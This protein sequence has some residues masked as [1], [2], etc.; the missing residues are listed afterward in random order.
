MS[1]YDLHCAPERS[2]VDGT[3]PSRPGACAPDRDG[4]DAVEPLTPD[5]D[6][7]EHDELE[8][9]DPVIDEAALPALDTEDPEAPLREPGFDDLIDR[10]WLEKAA[11]EDWDEER[12]PPEDIGLTIE[13]DSPGGDDDGAEVVDLD[14]GSLLTSLPSEGTELDLE[15]G[16]AQERGDFGA[17]ALGGVL[18]PEDDDEQDD[19]E[20]G[21]DDRFPVFEEDKRPARPLGDDESEIGPDELS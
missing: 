4:D 2:R 5:V 6:E 16:L 1:G 17:G 8:L 12:S 9:D 10:G 20:V 11:E 7:Q 13:L 14:V 19:R 18:L 15:P 3:G 21:D